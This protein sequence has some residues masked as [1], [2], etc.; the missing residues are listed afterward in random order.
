[1][2]PEPDSNRHVSRRRILS[3]MCL[4]I[5][6]SGHGK[7]RIKHENLAEINGLETGQECGYGFENQLY[8]GRD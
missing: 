4:P 8:Q 6:P 5:S 2:V 1:M 3:A 7:S